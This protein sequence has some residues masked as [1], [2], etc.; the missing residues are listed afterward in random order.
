MGLVLHVV[1][2]DEDSV[3]PV[4]VHAVRVTVAVL[5]VLLGGAPADK[6]PA[7]TSVAVQRMLVA[8][9]VQIFLK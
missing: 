1:A 8:R 6:H 2:R 7:R 3:R 4:V 5:R 9:F